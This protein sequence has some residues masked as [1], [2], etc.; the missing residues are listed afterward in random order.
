[1]DAY[2]PVSEEFRGELEVLAALK[3]HCRLKFR[4]DNGA[5]VTLDTTILNVYADE[6][7]VY[8]KTGS[9]LE[10]R[11]DRLVEVVG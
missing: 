7:G 4:A 5:V 6:D 2:Q 8:L 9:G 1:M 10:L 3:K 11:L